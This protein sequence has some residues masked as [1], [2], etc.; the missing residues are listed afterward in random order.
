MENKKE[1]NL[2]ICVRCGKK[3]VV[4]QYAFNSQE[5]VN[6]SCLNC[7]WYETSDCLDEE[8]INDLRETYEDEF[9]HLVE[10]K[11]IDEEN[12]NEG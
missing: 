7:G 11:I 3:S 1:N 5:G 9:K 2:S 10:L 4:E 6:R 12:L 8:E